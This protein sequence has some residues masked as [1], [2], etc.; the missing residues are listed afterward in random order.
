MTNLQIIGTVMLL[1]PM[2]AIFMWTTF[3]MWL[4]HGGRATI[5]LIL[6]ATFTAIWF[7][8]AYTLFLG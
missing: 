8:I 6:G 4:T 1:L 5:K 3:M 2:L 7:I